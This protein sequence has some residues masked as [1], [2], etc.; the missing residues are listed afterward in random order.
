MRPAQTPPGQTPFDPGTGGDPLKG[1]AAVSFAVLVWAGWIVATRDQVGTLGPIDIALM[2]Y[3]VP[4]VLLAPIWWRK[5]LFP[6][7]ES[8]W[9]MTVMIVGWGAPFVMLTAKGLETVPAALFGPMVPAM[10]P[11]LVGAWDRLVGGA[12]LGPQRA[13]GLALIAGSV[14]LIVGPAIWRD[15]TGFLSGAPWLFLAACGWSAFTV[16]YRRSRLNG[17]EAT[18]YVCVWSVP[19]LIAATLWLGTGLPGESWASLGWLALSQGVLSGVGAVAGYVYAVRHLGVARTSSFTSL[20]PMGAALGAWAFLGEVPGP[21]DWAS[22]TLAC[23]GVALANG[24]WGAL[25]A[26]GRR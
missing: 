23:V 3:G 7:G 13:A 5:G 15:D 25:R 9:V 18:A 21:L 22:V 6:R 12:P 11:L 19:F 2:R 4:A 24:A 16:A 10:L 20:V 1:Y 8:P 17:I 14:A 26:R